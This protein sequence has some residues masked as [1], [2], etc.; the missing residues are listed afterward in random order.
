M[1]P[2]GYVTGDTSTGPAGHYY[3]GPSRRRIG[4][5]FGRRRRTKV[6][7]KK[8]LRK[9]KK[10]LR[11]RRITSGYKRI[12]KS[13]KY[14]FSRS[15]KKITRKPKKKKPKKKKKK[16]KVAKKKKKVVYKRYAFGSM[17]GVTFYKHCVSDK[18]YR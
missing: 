12:K 17:K 5:G 4:A 6:F 3:L 11:K 14:S 1:H 16:K 10:Q 13:L 15:T 9:A 7:P 2:P 18:R 8:V